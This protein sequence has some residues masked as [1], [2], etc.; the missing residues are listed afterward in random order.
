MTKKYV[1]LS[2]TSS[3][4]EGGSSQ[5]LNIDS[6]FTVVASDNV[7]GTN[8]VGYTISDSNDQN[9]P[10]NIE[11]GTLV[12]EGAESMVERGILSTAMYNKDSEDN[13]VSPHVRPNYDEETGEWI[14]NEEDRVDANPDNALE[15]VQISTS[16]IQMQFIDPEAHVE[17]H[18][19][20][21]PRGFEIDYADPEHQIDATRYYFPL[22]DGQEHTISVDSSSGGGSSSGSTLYEHQITLEFPEQNNAR[23]TFRMFLSTAVPLNTNTHSRDEGVTLDRILSIVNSEISSGDVSELRF[24]CVGYWTETN[25][26]N[27]TVVVGLLK[28]IWFHSGEDYYEPVINY[29]EFPSYI[30]KTTST[31]YR[32]VKDY[33]ISFQDGSIC[34]DCNDDDIQPGE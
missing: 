8:R 13:I 20:I 15:S 16:Q 31:R 6:S 23:A 10:A 18:T 22:P 2:F 4:G 21:T 1:P 11:V 5:T 26:D 30:L 17:V 32:V 24:P 27:E 34:I 33:V 25:S 29:I 19:R 3:G 28:D 12:T 7:A 9:I 14:S